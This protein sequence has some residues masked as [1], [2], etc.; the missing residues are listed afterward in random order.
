LLKDLF[1]FF[2]MPHLWFLCYNFSPSVSKSS[3]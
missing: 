3:T 1:F 2:I